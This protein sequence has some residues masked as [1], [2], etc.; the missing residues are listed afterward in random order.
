MILKGKLLSKLS[1]EREKEMAKRYIVE[2]TS[3]EQ[4]ELLMLIAAGESSARKLKRANI[5]LLSDKSKKD[6]EI[7]EALHTS[8]STIER[9]RKRFVLEGLTASLNERPR[10]GARCKLDAKGEAILETLAQSKPPEG[11]KRWTMQLLAD[12]LVEL[13]VVDEISDETIR[14]HVKKSG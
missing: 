11:R 8:V 14:K 10:P 9:T 1:S 2:L 13:K 12:R 4:D 7:A 6:E 5:L 3:S